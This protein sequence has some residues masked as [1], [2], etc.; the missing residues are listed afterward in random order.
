MDSPFKSNN[1]LYS[2]LLVNIVGENLMSGFSLNGAV[3]ILYLF[4]L[5]V[6]QRG[7]LLMRHIFGPA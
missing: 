3:L 1:L 7:D 6:V 2:F 5:A 4:V